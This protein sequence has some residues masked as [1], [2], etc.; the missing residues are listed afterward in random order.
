MLSR[1]RLIVVVAPLVAVALLAACGGEVS[2]RPP[3]SSA[4]TITPLLTAPDTTEQATIGETTPEDAPG[5]A[6]PTTAPGVAT[7][8]SVTSTTVA[9]QVGDEPVAIGYEVVEERPH[10]TAA[11]TQGLVFDDGE[12]WESTGQ[13]ERSELRQLDPVTGEV[14]RSEPLGD[15]LFGEGLALIDDHFIQL[16]WQAGRALVWDRATMARVDAHSYEGEGWGL[17]HDGERLVMSDGS[18]RLTF[19]DPTTF[20]VTGSVAVTVRGAPLNQLNELECIDGEV[21]A[22]VWQ[23]DHIVRIDPTTG[24]VTGT[25][26]LGEIRPDVTLDGAVLNGIAYDETT[27]HFLVTGKYWPTLFVLELSEG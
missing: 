16:T 10:D 11:F 25:L 3:E 5:T 13:Y 23:T 15:E 19:R 24:V 6:A 14:V 27:G 21:W 22:N 4:D 12:L 20:E 26:F 8:S 7:E 1:S 2:L 17:C 18:D 9:P